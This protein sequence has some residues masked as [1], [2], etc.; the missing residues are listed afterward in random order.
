MSLFAEDENETKHLQAME[1]AEARLRL[2][3]I[4]L[5]DY[6]SIVP[7]VHGCAGVFHLA[8]P[9]IVDEVQDP[10]V[11]FL[12]SRT[13][14]SVRKIKSLSLIWHL[15]FGQILISVL[16]VIVSVSYIYL[17]SVRFPEATSGPGDQ[18]NY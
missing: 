13:T 17:D 2:F 15:K 11:L 14:I 9:C 18:G 4:D 16:Y 5:L 6:G 8:S 10:E 7:A 12:V 1:G 3:Q